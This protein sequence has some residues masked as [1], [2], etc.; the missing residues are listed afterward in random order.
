MSGTLFGIGV[1]PGDPMLLT[2]QAAHRLAMLDV[3]AYPAPLSGDSL[4][5]SIAAAHLPPGIPEI[6]LRMPFDPKKRA[7]DVYDK[8]AA[9]IA[10][11]LDR[12]RDVGV[13]CEGDP[14]FFGSF[15]YLFARLGNR[16]PVEILPG[17]SSLSAAAAALG[18]P[19]TAREDALAVIPATRPAADIERLIAGSEA[20]AIMRLGRHLPK[21]WHVLERLGLTG[22]ALYVERASQTAQSIRPLAEAVAAAKHGTSA[23]FAMILIHKRGKAWN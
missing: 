13:L 2:L 6:V 19:L 9:A 4:A 22:Q 5:R 21:V 3:V 23:Y 16:Y 14:L 18:H 11:A 8:G 12:G 1:G 7:D 10:E 20:A 15:L 17:V